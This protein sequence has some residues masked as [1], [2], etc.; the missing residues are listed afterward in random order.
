MDES[1]SNLLSQFFSKHGYLSNQD[2][3]Y[4]DLVLNDLSKRYDIEM[5]DKKEIDYLRDREN[6]DV[7]VRGDK[8]WFNIPMMNKEGYFIIQGVKKVPLIQE[9]KSRHSMFFTREGEAIISETRL[10]GGRNTMKLV[11]SDEVY[12]KIISSAGKYKKIHIVNLFDMWD[13]M[14]GTSLHDKC[15]SLA[16]AFMSNN[17]RKPEVL[18]IIADSILE[19]NVISDDL[20]EYLRDNIMGNTSTIEVLYTILYMIHGCVSVLFGD[21]ENTD[22]DHCGYKVYQSSGNIISNLI[23]R[24]FNKKTG[25]I[26]KRIENELY[27]VMKTGTI[28]INNIMRSKMVVQVSERSTLDKISTVR[29]IVV[30]T[31][32]NSTSHAMR[33]IHPTQIGFVCPCETP[34]GKQVGLIK[35]LASTCVLSPRMDDIYEEIS[36]LVSRE[37]GTRWIIYNGTVIGFYSNEL[38]KKIKFLKIKNPYLSSN[39]DS[40]GNLHIRTWEGRLMRPL[41]KTNGKIFRW[42]IIENMKWDE[43]L[44][45]NIIEYVDPLEIDRRSI[46]KQSYGGNPKM[47]THMEIHPSTMFG[48]SASVLPFVNHNHGARSIFAASMVKQA[49]QCPPNLTLD[50]KYL[51]YGQKPLIYNRITGKDMLELNPNGINVLVSI[52]SYSGY[53]QEDA[54]IMKKSFA[55]RQ[56]FS[57]INNKIKRLDIGYGDKKVIVEDRKDDCIHL[58]NS[59]EEERERTIWVIDGNDDKIVNKYRSKELLGNNDVISTVYRTLQV[60]DKLAS[61][62]AQKGVVGRLMR[63]ED[64]PFGDDGVVPDI[65]I[66]PHGIPSRMTMGQLFE[67]ILGNKCAV[68]G[69]F[70]DGT[71]FCNTEISD[72]IESDS[73]E[74]I[75]GINGE[76]MEEYASIDIVYYMALTHQV[77]DKIYV[78][79]IGPRNEFSHQPVSGKAKEGGLRFGEMEMDLLIA[80]G[81][82]S[83]LNDIS[84]NSDMTSF[85][86][87]RNCGDFPIHGKNCSLC[88][89]KQ[90]SVLDMPYSVKVLKDIMLCGNISI[91][92]LLE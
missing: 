73:M 4:E 85:K 8:E 38:Y 77:T 25:Q 45:S 49:M 13:N 46:C 43:L 41:I 59:C 18:S 65:I 15:A 82:S 92:I 33:Q 28:Q 2:I 9:S 51:V 72:L 90:I 35:N 17:K 74:F 66:N 19:Q 91:R 71:P 12:I 62:H 37:L 86:V 42:N 67:G 31:D 57:S 24:A 54:I 32:D 60:G 29:R 87:C 36:P 30:P 58:T 5:P 68:D 26:N 89:S 47:F 11:L 40:I 88:E 27:S 39:I 80:Y 14:D 63:D 81:A 22:R 61:R 21:I 64:M 3:I 52:M 53:N 83:L 48:M 78:R 56:G 23:R 70:S 84:N 1:R 44:R 34:E 50:G 55:E 20:Y 69:K 10:M 76:I 7:H 79:S 6:Y 16:Y 75:S